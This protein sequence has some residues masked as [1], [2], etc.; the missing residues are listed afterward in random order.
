MRMQVYSHLCP[1]STC[2]RAD[3]TDTC[4]TANAA[5]AATSAAL[6]GPVNPPMRDDS[7]DLDPSREI[8]RPMSSSWLR[9]G[10]VFV[11]RSPFPKK[12]F[13]P[14]APLLDIMPV[15]NN[16]SRGASA[17]GSVPD[18]APPA[19]TP[20]QCALIALPL[21]PPLTASEGSGERGFDRCSLDLGWQ[22]LECNGPHAGRWAGSA[23]KSAALLL[24]ENRSYGRGA[25]HFGVRSVW[26]RMCRSNAHG[27]GLYRS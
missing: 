14:R 8:W 5:S 25:V 22:L 10:D 19:G 27:D 1:N 7:A 23:R 9:S 2:C 6:R 15:S 17:L 3:T 24:A 26:L 16:A 20:S 11:G 13:P 21:R 12:S 4:S 18:R